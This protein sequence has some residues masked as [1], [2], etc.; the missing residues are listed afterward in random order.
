MAAYGVMQA[1]SKP[2]LSARGVTV[3]FGSRQTPARAVDGVD[4]DLPEHTTV[5]LVGESGCGKSAF[6]LALTRL[7]PSPPARYEGG[8]VL[9]RGQPLP[10][11][12]GRRWHHLRGGEIAYV[13]QEPSR[14]LNPL[15]RVGGQ[16]AEAVRQHRRGVNA[17]HEARDLLA[18]VGLPDASACARAYPHE[19]SGGMQQRVVIAM[20]LAGQPSLLIADEPTTALDVTTQAEVLALIGRLQRELGMTMLLITH[21]LGLVADLADDVYVMY[22]GQ[23][24]EAGPVDSVLRQPRHPYTAGLLRAVPR[25]AQGEGRLEG[26][27]GAVP[28]AT[29]WPAGCR[30]SPRCGKAADICCRNAVAWEGESAGAGVRCLFPLAVEE[31]DA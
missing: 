9:W 6:S 12:G 21:N 28:A 8:R 3:S 24:V 15:M 26:I 22:A 27:A 2:L 19:L 10:E 23:I 13:F 11:G 25:L 17:R 14:A 29:R 31:G 30:F 1:D 16:V 4:L 7:L 5:A 18:R 20:A